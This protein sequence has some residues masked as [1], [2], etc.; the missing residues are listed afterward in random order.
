MPKKI[1][2]EV[3][4]Q[5]MLDAGIRPVG[6]YKNATTPW[7]SVCMKCGEEISPTL[8][9][10]LK[11]HGCAYCAKLRVK[12]ADAIQKMMEFRLQPLEP[13]SGAN[14]KWKCECM[15]CGAIVSPKYGDIQ[16]GKGG[17]KK[18]GIEKRVDP[19]QYSHD[20]ATEILKSV[21]LSPLEPYRRSGDKWKC[22]C[23]T[24]GKTVTPMLGTIVT[25]KSGCRYCA[26]I[27]RGLSTRLNSEKARE[28]MIA[29]GYIPL[30]PYDGKQ[31]KWESRCI[32]CGKISYPSLNNVTSRNSKCIYCTGVKVDPEDAVKIM[33]AS[34]L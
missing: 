10:V 2:F 31:K 8:K 17:C 14:A 27:K 18:C 19:R 20:E 25:D 21:G 7:L 13:Y 22:L 26:N 3:A 12:P 11:K 9:N 32:D 30:T 6:P 4:R 33:L 28:T 15:D 5:S 1:D 24:C 34:N 23:L 16:Q 29:A